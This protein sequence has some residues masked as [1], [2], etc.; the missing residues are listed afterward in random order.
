MNSEASGTRA[1]KSRSE[2]LEAARTLLCGL[3]E[4]KLRDVT[5]VD[6]D[7][8]SWPLDELEVLDA[9]TSW[10]RMPGRRLRLIGS[11]F[12]VLERDQSRFARWRKQFMHALDCLTPTEIEPS[13]MPCLLLLP[14]TAS[15]ELFDRERWYGKLSDERRSIV[16]Q[17]ERVD[18]VLQRG[19]P[20]WPATVLGL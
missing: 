10:A 13:D 4:S 9:L 19:E 5:V 12:D 7:F 8:A 20:A 18:A 16:L 3:P 14:G 6:S 15:L 1:I 2:F 17:Q 11:R